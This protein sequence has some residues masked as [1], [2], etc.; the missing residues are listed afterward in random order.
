VNDDR[1]R[2]PVETPAAYRTSKAG[3][4]LPGRPLHCPYIVVVQR[5]VS[6]AF[7]LGV[8]GISDFN[9]LHSGAMHRRAT[10]S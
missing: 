4:A 6:P 5:M 8:D 3:S 9:A 2:S 7:I 10:A 1:Q